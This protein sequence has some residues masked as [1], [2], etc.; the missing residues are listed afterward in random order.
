MQAV[1]AQ[2]V[3]DALR[4]SSF[5]T[6]G[7]ARSVGVGG[8]MSAIGADF[9]MLSLNPAGIA[10]YR[11]SEFMISPA[12]FSNT[13]KSTLRNSDEG[14]NDEQVTEFLISN[15]GF[16]FASQPIGS[17]WRTSNFGIGINKVGDYHQTFQFFGRSQGSIT[18]RYVELANGLDPDNLGAFE[19]GLAY[20]SGAIYDFDED[21]IYESDYD[22]NRTDLFKTQLVESRGFN[23]ELVFAYGANYNE[24]LL[25]G[26]SVGVPILSFDEDKTYREEDEDSDEVPFFNDLEYKEF[27]NTSGNGF[28]AKFGAIYKITNF[29][30]VGAGFHTRTRYSLTDNFI[31]S[32][33]YD[34][35]D[36]NGNSNLL[37]TSPDGSFNYTLKTPWT[38]LGSFGAV[39]KRAGFISAEIQYT[40]YSKAEFDFTTQGNGNA[41][42]V[43]QEEANADI[44]NTLGEAIKI[45]A[46]GEVAIDNF[47]LRGGIVLQQS[48][49][50]DDDAFDETLNFGLGIRANQFF[51]DFAYQYFTED[52]GFL[53][54]EVDNAVQPFVEN[55]VRNGRFFLTLGYKWR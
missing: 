29:V 40:D 13:T 42:I 52:Q 55:D 16:V 3:A 17:K 14:E 25:F 5:N 53:P 39:I 51:I 35:T 46:G 32:V 36:S 45:K 34:Y 20:S 6:L 50:A 2:G 8:S 7:T 10:A 9:S 38:V 49:F 37:N 33:E 1:Q 19:D 4:Y 11:S 47:R 43:E 26:A 12:V 27:L 15:V 41:F 22:L 28:N 48:P 24:K 18:D 44:R 23:T 21:R 30:S 31:T 54:Y